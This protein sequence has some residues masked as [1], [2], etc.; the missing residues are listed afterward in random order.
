MHTIGPN[1]VITTVPAFTA[2]LVS[3]ALAHERDL[4][5]M[6]EERE[7]AVEPAVAA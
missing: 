4:V 2:A 7:K 5:A 6:A 1:P 3:F